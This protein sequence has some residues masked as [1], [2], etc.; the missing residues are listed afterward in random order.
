MHPFV[1][2]VLAALFGFAFFKCAEL[3]I[4]GQFETGPPIML[5]CGYATAW[6]GRL[7]AQGE[8]H[9]LLDFLCRTIDALAVQPGAA[10][11]SLEGAASIPP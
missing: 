8:Q 7:F 11:V 4:K 3:A 9:F 10:A 5:V 1:I 2:A 6:I